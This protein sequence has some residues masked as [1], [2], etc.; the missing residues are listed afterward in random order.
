M[1]K[2]DDSANEE[3]ELETNEYKGKLILDQKAQH[4]LPSVLSNYTVV[5]ASEQRVNIY[6]LK[7][8]K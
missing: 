5:F 1:N 8:L 6:F 7:S 2:K 4:S 3:S